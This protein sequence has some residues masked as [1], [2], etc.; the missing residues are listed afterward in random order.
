MY[1][2]LV[3]RFVRYA[4]FNTRSDSRSDTIP[5]TSCQREFAELLKKELMEIGL[6][7]VYINEFCFVHATLLSNIEKEVPV[8]GFISHMDTANFNAEGVNPQLHAGY[9][10]EDIV[11]NP[12]QNIVLRPSEFPNLK[13]YIGQTL[14][15]TD[16]TTLLGADDKAGIAEIIEAVKYLINHPEILH[17]EVRIAFGPDEEIGRGADKFNVEEFGAKYAYTVDGG[18]VGELE[19]ESF[20]AADAEFTIRGK[21]VHPGT[22]KGIM[23]NAASIAAELVNMLPKEEVPEKTSGY[24][25]FYYLYNINGNC[26]DANVDFIIRDHDKEKFLQRKAFVQQIADTLNAKYGQ[27][28]V[29]LS[30][31]DEYYNMGDVIRHHMEVV[32]IAEKAMKN[33][34]IKPLIKPIRGGTDGSK[35]SFMGLPTPNIFAGGE[36]FHGKYEFVAVESMEKATS[37]I[38]EIIKLYAG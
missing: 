11:L 6:Q 31:K 38:I 16:G 8:V 25:G 2:T 32:D 18:V 28:T 27:Q 13:N 36:N 4:K 24:E 17:G 10:G 33:L 1:S 19:Y 35:I 15:T 9:D 20:N 30:L 5:S 26:E 22:A 12:E 29:S 14:I 7:N 3:E 37:T 21:S 34:G 23:K